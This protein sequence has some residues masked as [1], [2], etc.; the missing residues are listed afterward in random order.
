MLVLV[1]VVLVYQGQVGLLVFV[2]GLCFEIVWGYYV[3]VFCF[4][5]L[6]NG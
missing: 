2:Y 5:M 4:G 6:L 1:F 3:G